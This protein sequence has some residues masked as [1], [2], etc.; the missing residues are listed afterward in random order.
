MTHF[1]TVKKAK[2]SFNIFSMQLWLQETTW[3][4]I[5]AGGYASRDPSKAEK[6]SGN[7]LWRQRTVRISFDPTQYLTKQKL[8]LCIW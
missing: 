3:L 5:R 2:N 7:N 1:L 6:H 4:L 8:S